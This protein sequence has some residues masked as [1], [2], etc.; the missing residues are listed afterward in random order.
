MN[1]DS[2]IYPK[3]SKHKVANVTELMH[4]VPATVFGNVIVLS[5]SI[6]IGSRRFVMS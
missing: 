1:M 4:D 5:S 3:V 2:C 6:Q